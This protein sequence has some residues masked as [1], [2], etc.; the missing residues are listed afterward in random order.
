MTPAPAAARAVGDGRQRGSAALDASGR[1]AL[2][3]GTGGDGLVDDDPPRAACGPRAARISGSTSPRADSCP[4]ARTAAGRLR[5]SATGI[6]RRLGPWAPGGAP[7]PWLR[8][9]RVLSPGRSSAGDDAQVATTTPDVLRPGTDH[10]RPRIRA[11]TWCSSSHRDARGLR[12]A[13]R[14]GKR[15]PGRS[16]VPRRPTTAG[17]CATQSDGPGER[18]VEVDRGRRRH[19]SGRR[20]PRVQY[21]AAGGRRPDR[22][23][24]PSG[25]G[26]ATTTVPRGPCGAGCPASDRP[27]PRRRTSCATPAPPTHSRWSCPG[28]FNTS[29]QA[30]LDDAAPGGPADE[31][32]APR[33]DVLETIPPG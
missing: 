8:R 14:A 13:G 15:L 20:A 9:T 26:R 3:P 28:S 11:A 32:D 23:A 18:D 29:G 5:T 24:L 22:A 6:T 17:A 16:F 31:R 12:R 25:S 1:R 7:A 30:L 33:L 4:A 10:R 19:R 21:R 2:E 27:R